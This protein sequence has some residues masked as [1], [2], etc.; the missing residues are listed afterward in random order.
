MGGVKREFE[1]ER[2][3]VTT[4]KDVDLARSKRRMSNN[5]NETNQRSPK[6]VVSG[7]GGAGWDKIATLIE[8]LISS[9]IRKVGRPIYEIEL[10]TI[11]GAQPVGV[12][13]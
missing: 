2:T 12:L 13:G 7:Y 1:W 10:S 8:W 4:W 11:G 3:Q 5:A 9:T 6:L